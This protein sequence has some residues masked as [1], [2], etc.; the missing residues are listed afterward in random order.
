MTGCA[1]R[2]S[3][4]KSRRWGRG[5]VAGGGDGAGVGAMG[6]AGGM[7]P[8]AVPAQIDLERALERLSEIGRSVVWLH[9]V[10]GY[11]HEEI[12]EQMGKTVSFSKSQ[13]ARAHVRLRWMLDEGVAR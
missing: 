7:S 2:G 6:G 3:S 13:L 5:K 11:T 9:D 1:R 8:G 10:E 12:A 4:T